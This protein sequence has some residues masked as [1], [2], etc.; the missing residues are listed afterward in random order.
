MIQLPTA[1]LLVIKNNKLLL[2]FSGNKKAWYLPGGKIDQDENSKS[3]LIREIKE[4]LDVDLLESEL[5]Y[6]CHITAE[7]Y[8]EQNL[9]MEQ[10]CFLYDLK[11]DIK[12]TNEIEAVGYFSFEEYLQEEIQVIGVLKVYEELKKNQLIH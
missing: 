4:E 3:A 7:A 8:G 6:F 12:P 5:N 1:G 10:D 11:E 2:T 9:L